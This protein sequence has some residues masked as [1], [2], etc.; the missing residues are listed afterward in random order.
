MSLTLRRRV[1][2]ARLILGAIT[3]AALAGCSG[4]E[5]TVQPPPPPPVPPPPLPPPPPPPPAIKLDTTTVVF[6]DTVG[7]AY[8]SKTVRI[9]NSGSG[10]LNGLAIA[11]TYGPGASN[12]L[13]YNVSSAEAPA[14]LT[15]QPSNTGLADGF[16]QA[17]VAVTAS[18]ASN[19]PQ[20]IQV[21]FVLTA[22]PP[23]PPDPP[24]AEPP[25]APIPGVVI[26]AT[27]NIQKCGGALGTASAGVVA[28][29]N[30]DFLIVMGDN[31]YPQAGGS[32]DVTLADFQNCY[33]PVW[34][35]FM[36][37]TRAAVGG[38]E[39]D[40]LGRSAP[41]DAYFGVQ[42]VGNPGENWYA[43]NVGTGTGIWRIIVLN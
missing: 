26:A 33:D 1:W 41:A 28:T 3:V 35:R 23:P 16:Y 8:G 42:R 30:P 14:T 19:S 9:T 18:G 17:T 40:S 5:P 31:V 4:D 32:G 43:F 13:T 39:Q 15:L 27:G 6:N 7:T 11:I 20:N 21:S 29:L 2:A 34:G 37:V 36:G 12:W 38:R 10:T 25:P 24:P 22:Q